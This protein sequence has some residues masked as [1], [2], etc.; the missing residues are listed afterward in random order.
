MII[1]QLWEWV[2]NI[3]I[4]GCAAI[5]WAIA[6]FMIALLVSLLKDFIIGSIQK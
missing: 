6:L 1:L 3:F 4:L 5:I 2:V